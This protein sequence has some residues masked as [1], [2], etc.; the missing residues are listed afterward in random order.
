MRIRRHTSGAGGWGGVA[1]AILNTVL[2]PRCQACGC[3]LPCPATGPKTTEVPLESQRFRS[4]ATLKG[5]LCADCLK[6]VIVIKSPQC[7]CC[8]QMFAGR[9]G[10]DHLCGACSRRLWQFGRARAA[11]VFDT[12]LAALVHHLKYNARTGLA[13]PLGRLMLKKLR[14]Y[15]DPAEFDALVPIPLHPGRLRKRGFNQSALLLQSWIQMGKKVPNGVNASLAIPGLLERIKPTESQTGLGRRERVANLKNAFRVPR[16][17]TVTG[18]KI[19]LVDDVFTTGATANECARTLLQAGA[20]SVDVFTLAR[21]QIE[22]G[23][24]NHGK[25]S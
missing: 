8:G 19:L 15:W 17:K 14:V 13:R 20:R 16:G 24:R 25:T 10:P 3:V 4:V 9:E 18:F 2:P 5:Y 23:T 7:T 12:S 6:D 22:Y 11:A 21:T 1:R